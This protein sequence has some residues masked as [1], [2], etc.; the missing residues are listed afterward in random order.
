PVEI[1]GNPDDTTHQAR[2]NTND[3]PAV[4]VHEVM[5]YLGLNEGYKADHHLFNTQDRPGVMGPEALDPDGPTRYLHDK[6]LQ[7]IQ[8]VS[9]TAGPVNNLTPANT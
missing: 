5:H 2:W 3:N 8:N 1:T 9:D 7:L 6:D 4:L